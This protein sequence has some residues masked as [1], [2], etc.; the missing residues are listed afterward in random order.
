MFLNTGNERQNLKIRDFE[1]ENIIVQT[2][3]NLHFLGF[4][5]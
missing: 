1:K 5:F 2:F 3:Q 4:K